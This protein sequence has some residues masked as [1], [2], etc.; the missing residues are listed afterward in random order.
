MKKRNQ[1]TKQG[2]RALLVQIRQHQ[3]ALSFM[4]QALQEGKSWKQVESLVCSFVNRV[5]AMLLVLDRERT[6]APPKR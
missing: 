6:D 3:V 5:P 2:V 1:L 4:E